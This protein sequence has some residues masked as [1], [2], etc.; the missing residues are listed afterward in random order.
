MKSNLPGT[1]ESNKVR[2]IP[3]DI[4][5]QLFDVIIIGAGVNGAGIARDGAMRGLKVLLLDKGDIA[6]GTSS[7]STR[8]IHGGLRYL[9]H[10]EIGLVRESL[11][12]RERLLNIAPHLVKPLPL[13]IP[14][15]KQNRRG[16]LTVR[17]GMILYDLL[18]FDKSLSRHRMLSREDAMTRAPGLRSEGLLGAALYRDAQ[19]EY[20]E[21]LVLENVLSAIEHSAQALTYAR[22]DGFIVEDES[23]RGVEFTDLLG[24]TAHTARAQIVV[25]ASGPWV[26]ELLARAHVRAQRLIGGTKGSHIIVEKFQGAPSSCALYAEARADRRPFFI[27]PWNNLYL[28]GTTDIPESGSLDCVTASQAEIDYLLRETNRLIPSAAL[29]HS[30]VLYTYSGIR[31]LPYVS[32]RD[33][34]SI[35]RRH[36]IHDHASALPCFVSIV[37]GKLTTYRSLAEQAVD[38]IFKKLKRRAVKCRTA[39]ERLPGATVEDFEAFSE[40]FKSES[41]LP[42]EVAGRLLRIYGARAGRIVKL[43]SENAELL[44]PFSPITGAIGAEVIFSFQNELAA[45]LTD[46]LMR[47]TLVGL[48]AAVG[49]DAVEESARIAC[50]YLGWDEERAAREVDEYRKYI[51]RLHPRGL[52]EVH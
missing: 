26:D 6:S 19:V 35:T 40:Q 33:P 13:L 28:I 52:R 25:N 45:T 24:D 49:L 11:R 16:R 2:P 47:R 8:L 22:V 51:L 43:A 50:K 37:G 9:E 21:R 14:I 20:A 46:C 15:Y 39:E 18:S 27:I 29:E 3:S 10:G 12:E 44:K 34:A 5:N 23:V 31:P 42:G 32:D 1:Q 48:D 7:W 4:N 38:L 36:F 30:S 17:A 41:N